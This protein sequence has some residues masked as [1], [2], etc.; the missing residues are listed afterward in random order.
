L[1]VGQRSLKDG[2]D[3]IPEQEIGVKVFGRPDTYDNA[4]DSIVRTTISDLRKRVDAYFVA[5]GPHEPIIMEIPRGAYM[6]V[7]YRRDSR[8][9]PPETLSLASNAEPL[10]VAEPTRKNPSIFDVYFRRASGICIVALAGACLI[11]WRQHSVD[12]RSMHPWKYEPAL[13]SFW[14]SFLAGNRDTDIVTEDSSVLLVQIMSKQSVALSDYINKTYLGTPSIQGAD[15]ETNNHL[16][17]ISRKALGKASDFR[18]GMSIKSLDPQNPRMHFYNAREYTP[19][20][21]QNDNIV[22]LGNPTSNPWDQWFENN[23][24]FYMNPTPQGDSPVFNRAARAGE[25][26]VYYPSHD[27]SLTYCVLAF[28]PKP[29]HT[30]DLLFIQGTTSEATEAGG[31]FLLSNDR[32][33]EL[34]RQMHV[35]KLPYFE[36]LL[37]VSQVLGNALT[38]KIEAYRI[39]TNVH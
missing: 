20:L 1:Y 38:A 37:N 35:T 18:L 9:A 6:P 31:Q 34:Q 23:L 26:G 7:F 8:P 30:G 2:C 4:N 22:L 25:S 21:L 28:M 19:R 5:E 17:L 27:K 13:A 24:N 3:H 39:Y 15:P 14:S 36:V 29:D 33:S 11:L 32:L 16:L 12:Q 10:P